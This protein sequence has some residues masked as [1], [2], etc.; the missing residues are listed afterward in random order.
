MT[1][2]TYENVAN[3]DNLRVSA[4]LTKIAREILNN[5]NINLS[6]DEFWSTLSAT[7]SKY[8]NLN[9]SLLNQRDALQEKIDE[10]HKDKK[11]RNES[12]TFDLPKYKSFLEDIGYL[13]KE[14]NEIP[15]TITTENVDP[16]IS[17]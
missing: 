15:V 3:N 9:K 6:E 2:V 10:W 8:G 16:E 4:S 11:N 14:N 5:S 13:M 17:I 1:S 12:G 7:L